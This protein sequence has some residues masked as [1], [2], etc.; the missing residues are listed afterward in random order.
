MSMKKTLGFILVLAMLVALFAGCGTTGNP[1]SDASDPPASDTPTDDNSV[2]ASSD[3]DSPYKFA[4]GNFETN[5]KGFP[6][7][8]Y[9]YELPFCTTD[10]VFTFWTVVWAPQAVD[11]SGYENM[12]FA[13]FERERTG[14]NIEYVLISSETR[15]ENFAV[16]LASDDLCDI[17]SQASYFYTSGPFKKAVLDE[18]WFINVYD[19]KDYCPN[20]IYEA[21][22]DP[23]DDSIYESVFYEDDLILTFYAFLKDPLISSNYMTRGDWL[24]KFGLTNDDIRT[25]DQLHDYLL[26]VKSEIDTCEFPWPMFASIDMAGTYSFASMDTLPYVSDRI[27]PTFVVDGKA[28]LAN[29]NESDREFVGMI[30]QWYSEGLINPNWTS[31]TNNTSFQDLT[32]TGQVGYLYCSPG[33]VTG[34]E[35]QTTNDPNCSWVP[36]HKPLKTLDQTVHMGN[37]VS[38]VTYGSSCVSAKCENI[39]LAVTWCDWRYS[40]TGCFD[41]SYGKEGVLWEYDENHNIVATDWALNDTSLTYAWK[42]M[43]YGLNSLAEHGMEDGMRKYAYPGGERLIDIHDYWKDQKN[44]YAWDWPSGVSLTDEQTARANQLMADIG[45]FVQ[46]N[47]LAFVDGSKPISE[48]DGY[49]EGLKGLGM[50]ELVGIYQDAYDAYAAG[51]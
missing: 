45:T 27:F 28:K 10:E 32:T 41:T 19:Y 36:L 11:E 50:D 46:E 51:A 34:Y 5:E 47:Y 44:D 39:P 9:E 43:F 15:S 17:S 1:S 7:S 37:K 22:K 30:Q 3:S 13:S 25:Y 14:V 33:E 49:I 35:A 29:M 12:P 31:F 42:C 2:S 48:W 8:N 20:Y 21:T 24:E 23:N 6:T 4:K 18:H 16:L 40:P 38:R 26:R